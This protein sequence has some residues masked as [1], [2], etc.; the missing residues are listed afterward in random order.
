MDEKPHRRLTVWN[1]AMD[2]VVQV[3]SA[4]GRFPASERFGFVSQM[5]RAALSIPSN[6]AEGAARKGPREYVRFLYTARGS[7]SELDTQIEAA[8]RLRYLSPRAASDLQR[9]LDELSRMLNGL[10]G[11]LSRNA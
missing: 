9:K 11:A 7:L 2:F 5:R 10:I 6:I 4:T 1:K 8:A 3:H